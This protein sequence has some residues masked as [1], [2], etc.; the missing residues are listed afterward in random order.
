M[1]KGFTEYFE[2]ENADMDSFDEA[3]EKKE[4]L[5]QKLE[6]LDDGFET[7]YARLAEDIQ[8]NRKQYVTQIKEI[9][10]KNYLKNNN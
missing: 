7:L 5:I 10:N 6:K 1:E 3:I 2:K 9:Q 4:E 8:N